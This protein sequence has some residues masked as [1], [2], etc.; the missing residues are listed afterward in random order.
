L[1]LVFLFACADDPDHKAGSDEDTSSQFFQWEKEA[2]TSGTKP[3]DTK[4]KSSVVFQKGVVPEV[5][6]SFS[7]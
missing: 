5:S 7:H 4:P 6:S 1:S 2:D 3:N